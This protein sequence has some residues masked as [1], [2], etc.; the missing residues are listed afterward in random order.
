VKPHAK[1]RHLCKRELID[2]EKSGICEKEKSR[3]A[4]KGYA[5]GALLGMLAFRIADGKI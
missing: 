1:Y 3:D 5:E 4:S 2:G